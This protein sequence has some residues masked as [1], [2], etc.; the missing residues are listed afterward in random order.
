M[1]EA[2]RKSDPPFQDNHGGFCDFMSM[3]GQPGPNWECLVPL[4]NLEGCLSRY[5]LFVDSYDQFIFASVKQVWIKWWQ[6]F[7][8][9]WLIVQGF[10]PHCLLCQMLWVAQTLSDRS[11]GGSLFHLWEAVKQWPLGFISKLAH[12]LMPPLL[13][14]L[15]LVAF[16]L[17]KIWIVLY[18]FLTCLLTILGA[19]LSVLWTDPIFLK[20][21]A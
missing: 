11:G 5:A 3:S 6:T 15:K 9:A 19:Q 10:C 13:N 2:Q 14:M 18:L 1:G 8:G 16:G 12:V 21:V 4:F 20:G 17:L 7:L